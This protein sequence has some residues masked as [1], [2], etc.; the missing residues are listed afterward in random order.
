MQLDNVFQVKTYAS[1]FKSQLQ[2]KKSKKLLKIPIIISE[3]IIDNI[4]IK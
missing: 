4:F 3:L 1:I 2:F